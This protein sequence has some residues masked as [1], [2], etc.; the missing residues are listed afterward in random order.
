MKSKLTLLL[1][2][3]SGLVFGQQSFTLQQ[4][5]DQAIANNVQSK[6]ARLD[7]E[8]AKKKIW[9]TTAIGLP[10]INGDVTYQNF[11]DIPTQVIPA[12]AFNPMASPDDF[13]AVKFGI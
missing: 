5:I 9:E 12:Q 4:A 2:V 1:I 11:L 10:N 6:N 7:I 13:A 8:I 3:L